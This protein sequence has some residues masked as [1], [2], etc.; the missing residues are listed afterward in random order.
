MKVHSFSLTFLTLLLCC[1]FS[2]LDQNVTAEPGQ[3]VNLTC[4][5]PDSKSVIVVEWRRADVTEEYVLL[6]RDERDRQMKDGDVSL[7]L[8]NVTT[9]DTGN[10]ECRVQNQG[11]RERK[12]ICSIYLNVS[13]PGEFVSLWIRASSRFLVLE[14]RNISDQMLVVPKDVVDETLWKVAGLRTQSVGLIVGLLVLSFIV[15]VA[16]ILIIKKTACLMQK[17]SAADSP[18]EEAV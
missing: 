16:A 7:V 15:A 10:Y 8:K 17:R 3:H 9:K 18:K 6:Y 2:T 11:N 12:H 4:T 13:P 5:V 14:V 1:Y